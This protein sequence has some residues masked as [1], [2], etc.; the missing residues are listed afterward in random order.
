MTTMSSLPFVLL[1]QGDVAGAL[2]AFF[3]LYIPYGMFYIFMGALIFA[4]VYGKTK[5]YG[6]AG[7]IFI[8]FCTLIGSA[9]PVE[10]QPFLLLL[11]GFIL[12]VMLIQMVLK[13]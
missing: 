3:D 1:M 12:A 8:L 7:I 9:V 13:K 10:I 4:V 6:I 5:S 11:I 2:K